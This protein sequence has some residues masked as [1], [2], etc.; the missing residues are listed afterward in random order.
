M[1]RSLHGKA[2][3]LHDCLSSRRRDTDNRLVSS[4][5]VISDKELKG[6]EAGES[7]VGIRKRLHG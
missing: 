1:S 4:F 6:E 7:L 3:L 2:L 5:L